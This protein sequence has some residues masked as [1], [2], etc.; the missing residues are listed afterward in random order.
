MN[1][2]HFYC[3]LTG[4]WKFNG[5][6]AILDKITSSCTDLCGLS[7]QGWEGLSSEHLRFLLE[8]CKKLQRLDLSGINVSISVFIFPTFRKLTFLER[9]Q[10]FLWTNSDTLLH[11]DD[12]RVKRNA[13]FIRSSW[14]EAILC[15]TG[16]GV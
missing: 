11:I 12:W 4:G 2:N 10:L 15:R 14:D 8:R 6:P 9:G 5:I 1:L 16:Y 13:F 3:T 7:L